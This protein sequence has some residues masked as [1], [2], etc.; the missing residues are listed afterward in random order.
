MS[1]IFSE[2]FFRKVVFELSKTVDIKKPDRKDPVRKM[3]F[4]DVY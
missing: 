4:Q 1:C 2:M 3:T